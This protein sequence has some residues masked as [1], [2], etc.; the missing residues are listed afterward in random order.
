M[1]DLYNE[2]DGNNVHSR[3]EIFY[4]TFT[5]MFIGLVISGT[6][7]WLT[8]L[9]GGVLISWPVFLIFAVAELIMVYKMSSGID[10]LSTTAASALFIVFS[11]IDGITLST[12]FLIYELKSILF[13]FFVAAGLFGIMA[14][15]G[16]FTHDDLS[17]LGPYLVFTLLGLLIALTVNLILQ[18][19]VLDIILSLLVIA[20]VM[21]CTS[22]DIY[23]MKHDNLYGRRNGHIYFAISLYLDFIN[24]F[25]HLLNLFGKKK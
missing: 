12:I 7:A 1:N 22:Y 16:Y 2:L 15:Y 11:A 6:T 4:K 25:L 18:S 9:I 17:R 5:W 8:S 20:T 23:E 19:K 10:Q 24:I 21:G 13:I 14:L 3:Q